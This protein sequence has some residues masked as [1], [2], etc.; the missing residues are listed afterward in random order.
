MLSYMQALEEDVVLLVRMIVMDDWFRVL[1]GWS[2][3]AHLLSS[4]Q[5]KFDLPSLLS[6]I[7]DC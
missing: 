6:L 5:L 2:T 3:A 7:R 4:W 1:W